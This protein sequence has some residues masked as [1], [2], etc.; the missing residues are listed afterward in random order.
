MKD[1]I[2]ILTSSEEPFLTR[3][4]NIEGR[5]R[6]GFNVGTHGPFTVAIPKAE[7]SEQ[8]VEEEI[9]KIAAPLRRLTGR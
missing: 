3:A 6:V 7:F 5:I 4:G 9:E 1:D 8:R 2:E